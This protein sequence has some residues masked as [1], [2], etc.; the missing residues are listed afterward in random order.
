M[1]TKLPQKFKFKNKDTPAIYTAELLQAGKVKISWYS[2]EEMVTTYDLLLT[3]SFVKQGT[4]VVLEDLSQPSY[5]EKCITLG[6]TINHAHKGGGI[7]VHQDLVS[8][9]FVKDKEGLQ[10]LVDVLYAHRVGK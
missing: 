2:S 3:E 6:L 8:G 5:V 1:I 10:A 7:E 9:V 4:W